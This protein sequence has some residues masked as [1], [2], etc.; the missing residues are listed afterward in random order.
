MACIV[1][2]QPVYKCYNSIMCLLHFITVWKIELYYKIHLQQDTEEYKQTYIQNVP[3]NV[4]FSFDIPLVKA[5]SGY[6]E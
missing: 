1:N 5:S 3:C 4:L 6:G 2:K